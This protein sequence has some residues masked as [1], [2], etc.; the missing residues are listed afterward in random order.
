MKADKSNNYRYKSKFQ[1]LANRLRKEMTKAE[2]C[3]WKYVLRAGLMKGYSFRRQRPVLDYIADFMCKELNL[4]IEVDGV[5]HT[6]EEVIEKDQTRQKRLEEAGFT[7]L[8]FTDEEVL[9]NINGVASTIEDWIGGNFTI[10]PPPTPA[11]GG[12]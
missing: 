5:T 12:D 9:K 3:L 1:P 11:S 7:V 8:R 10:I 4:I 6:W 2:A